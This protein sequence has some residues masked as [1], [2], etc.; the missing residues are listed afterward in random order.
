MPI[1]NI[2]N[3]GQVNFPDDMSQEDIVKAI[4]TDI[5]KKQGRPAEDVGFFEGAKAAI[6]RGVESL[7]GPSGVVAG[8]G[9]AKTAATGTEEETRAK[10]QAIKADQQKP[11]AAPGMTV[12]D[13]E[14]I[15][16]DKG[17]LAAAKEV[18]KYITEQVLTS[19]PQMAGPLAVGAAT[20]PFLTPVGGAVAGMATYGVQQF[21]N[22]LIRQAQEKDDPKELALTKAALTAAGT[23]PLGYFADRF[24]VGLGGSS[25]KIGEE[26]LEELSARRVAGEVG[27]G[28]ARGATRGIIAEAPTEVLEQAAE[29]WQAGLDLTGADAKREYKEA[30]FGA[31]AAGGG[32]GGVSGGVRSYGA[33]RPIT[34]ADQSGVSVPDE[35]DRPPGGIA[36]TN[37]MGLDISGQ[38]TGESIRR[39]KELNDQLAALDSKIKEADAFVKDVSSV[40]PEDERIAGAYDFIQG[41]AS[42]RA[43][44]LAERDAIA[45]QKVTAFNAPAQEGFDFNA[46]EQQVTPP[47]P[48]PPTPIQEQEFS[49]LPPEGKVG[50]TA[51]PTP[52]EVPKF[53][54]SKF[55]FVQ[56]TA[57]PFRPLESF[58]NSLK[59]AAVSEAEARAHQAE[60][61]KLLE[62]INEFQ[63]D[64]VGKD[65]EGRLKTVQNF[66]DQYSIAPVERQNDVAQLPKLF[67][68]MDA[69]TQ[70]QVLSEVSQMPKI[71]TVNGMKE[72][73]ARL[74]QALLD[75]SEAKL[76]RAK[77][78]AILPWQTH[79]D[80]SSRKDA[81]SLQ[82]LSNISD[83]F[84][85]PE[86]KAASTYLSAHA[87]YAFPFASALRAAAFDLGA[88]QGPVFRGQ[89]KEAAQAFRNWAAKNLDPLSLARFDATVNEFKLMGE[90]I[91]KR[92]AE[93]EEIAGGKKKLGQKFY[94][95]HPSVDQKIANN[96]LPGA[97]RELSN[98]GTEFQKGLAKKLMSLNLSTSI[99]VNK[100]QDFANHII[101]RNAGVEQAQVLDFLQ[102]AF[103]TVFN[104]NFRDLGNTRETYKAFKALQAGRLGVDQ[105]GLDAYYGQIAEVVEAYEAAV[106]VLDASGTYMPSLDSININREKGGN[107]TSTFL[108][109]VLHAA[110]H[111][112]LDPVN[113]DSLTKE[114]QTAVDELKRM[115][116]T[117]KGLLK[118]GNEVSS[119]DEFVVE[120][121][122]N[123]EFQRFL[124]DIPVVNEKQTVWDKFTKLIAKLFGLN[125]MLGYTLANANVIMQAAPNVSPEAKALNQQGK[126]GGYL[127]DETYRGGPETRSLVSKIFEKRGDW[128]DVKDSMPSFLSGLKDSLRKTA[129]GALTLRQLEDIVGPRVPPFKEFINRVE[130]MMDDRNTTLNDTKNIV[131]PW[132]KWQGDNPKKAKILN[133][134]MLDATR[135]NIDPDIND[136]DAMLNRAWG[137]IG[138]EG[139]KI[140]RQVRDFYKTQLNNHIEVL[141]ARKQKVLESE[142]V[143][144]NA[145]K[146][147]PEYRALK[148]HFTKNSIE[149]YFPIRRFGQYWLQVGK[150]KSKE[151]Y[152]FESASE[153][154][155]FQK[156]REKELRGTDKQ[157]S[158]GNSIKQMVND[159]LQDFEFLSK[160]KELVAKETGG[161]NKQ[162]KDNIIDSIEQMYLMTLPDQSIRRMFL[163]RQ[164]I[165]GMSQDMLRAFTAS[166]FRIAYQQSRFK[167]SD[168]LY[169][170][171]DAAESYIEGMET[172]ERKVYTDYI[173]E[174]EDR[175]GNIMNPPD[176]GKIPGMLSNLSFAWYM[177]APASAIVNML[178]VPAIGIPVVGAR[179][180]NAKTAKTMA[181]YARKFTT[182]GFKDPEGNW[183]FPSF[184]NKPGLFNERQK[185]AFDQFTADGLIDLTLTHD[186]VGLSETDSN[187]YTGRTQK[188]MG[189]LSAAFHG[190][191][192]FNREVVAM[193]SYDL[194][195]ER[196]KANGLSEDA[197]HKK[198]IDEAK[199]LT[200]KSMFD[201]STLNKPRYFQPA[202]AKVFLQFKQ[203]SQQM[204]YMLA[205]S[206]YEGFYKKFDANEL[207]DIAT[208]V[209]TT[210]RQD[211]QA[212]LEGAELDAAVRQYIKDFRSEGKKRLI[213]TLGSTFLFAGATGLPGWAALS[214]MMEMLNAAFAEEDE[215]EEPFNFDNAFKNW[216]NETFGGFIGDSI[217]RGI[218]SQVTGV[219]LSDRMGL[220]N[221]WFRDN[222]NTADEV[223]ATE[224]F[225]VSLMGPT[226]GLVT[227]TA[228]AVKQFNDG[229][230][231]R[232]IETF[233][234]AVLKNALKGSRLSEEGAMTLGGDVLVE[235]FSA[236]ELGA[237][238]LGFAP[239]RL[240][241]R[242]KA[243]IEMKSAEQE[244]VKKHQDLLN[245]FF[246]A[247]DT[248]NDDMRERVID[249]IERFNAANPG[250]AITDKALMASIKRRYEQ[251][252]LAEL[253][254][255]ARIKKKLIGQ[256][257]GMTG[258]AE[259]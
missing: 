18:P 212:E 120:A 172:D 83:K 154:N 150:G 121:Y 169:G 73:R 52:I 82:K 4:E 204:T 56:P 117:A 115:Y 155:A 256:L 74:D 214:A 89:D 41:A 221:L 136:S 184:S 131:K 95:I 63:E 160:L 43:Q 158:A 45:S 14:R 61:R 1:I 179:F 50:L 225:I 149:P 137:D 71:N 216:T 85:T 133:A 199:E 164:G 259:D 143:S 235:D 237:Q 79:E 44:L 241:Q 201:Y 102:G 78:S 222:R 90:K 67:T 127:L 49:L 178:G 99:S 76:G 12:E 246:M 6:G 60:V 196:A 3:V 223:S 233:T 51:A 177:T 132:M 31:A 104:D 48:T 215:E 22:F 91:R 66:F 23:A 29:R 202:Y 113:Y 47:T 231:D 100:E 157:I 72:L 252:A 62:D 70:Q 9:L 152:T 146:S 210:R 151:F 111:W 162:L 20:S 109:E 232:A 243:N 130:S 180:G 238:F 26:I 59:P 87:D 170:A 88:E 21:G 227:N 92:T 112:A 153:R 116:E 77:E 197:A 80:V 245:A 15:Y 213:G 188:V 93:A 33:T 147:H 54:T 2:P 257:E 174:L 64:S 254:G 203:F 42:Q 140:Y 159:N 242:Q 145:V 220:N 181:N 11:E 65:R 114:Q 191:E 192:K 128:N 39:E 175:L 32:I 55:M 253:T 144:P 110:T 125:N 173:R 142:G 17:F 182:T 97:L 218:A 118:F 198:A 234:P 36:S 16:K 122:S 25:K 38:R 183:S 206:A 176:T 239:E 240:A 24:T 81:E 27:K 249:K 40:N 190:A 30:F 251:R 103:P 94:V 58:F 200:Y 139:Q 207:Q 135:M 185:R 119:I 189:V 209:N 46:P 68:G 244:I 186:I 37:Q 229:H 124:K 108:H 228:N 129:L 98:K 35:T 84:K 230:I 13:F 156:K 57:T 161:T 96:D 226:A 217:S 75:Y 5:I 134:L 101:E 236:T 187:L 205:R 148:D 19:A 106:A 211:G 195:Y 107:N 166:A 167:H 165:Q 258:Y 141:L 219:A 250:D 224:A 105:K 69:Q 8:L 86:E 194:A 138:P 248:D 247:T 168:S 163:N 123:P 193:S 34:P 126:L 53:E 171:V 255:G 208:Q 10:M 7:T 28:V